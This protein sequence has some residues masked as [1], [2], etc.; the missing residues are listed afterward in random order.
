MKK[1]LTLCLA[2]FLSAGCL[3]ATDVDLKKGN[4][5]PI[6][7][8]IH[9]PALLP[10]LCYDGTTFTLTVPYDIDDLE[11]VISDANGTILYNEVKE[12][13]VLSIEGGN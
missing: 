6:G 5:G 8:P 12:G 9:A 7:G 1:F 11:I 13:A 10:T 2:A 4:G 3:A